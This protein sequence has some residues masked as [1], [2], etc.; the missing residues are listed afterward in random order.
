ME[1]TRRGTAAAVERLWP[2]RTAGVAVLSGGI[3][4]RNYRVDVE[5]GLLC[6][7]GWRQ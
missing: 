2:G 7:A 1:S 4:N 5:R 3:T 6:L